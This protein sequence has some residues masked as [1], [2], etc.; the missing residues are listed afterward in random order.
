LPDSCDPR[1][2]QAFPQRKGDA[3]AAS[4]V[5]RAFSDRDDS[6][7]AALVVTHHQRAASTRSE[8]EGNFLTK[9]PW[10]PV[11]PDRHTNHRRDDGLANRLLEPPRASSEL[12]YIGKMLKTAA[13]ADAEVRADHFTLSNSTSN[14]SVALGGMTPPAPRGP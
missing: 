7:R 9:C 14:T 4:A 11:V 10:H 6:L 3:I 1:L 13:A 2:C 5:H 12:I 8:D